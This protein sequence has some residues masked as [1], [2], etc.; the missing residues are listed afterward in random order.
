MSPVFVLN[1]WLPLTCVALWPTQRILS[2]TVVTCCL[3]TR[4]GLR[5]PDTTQSRTCCS[6]SCRCFHRVPSG[7]RDTQSATSSSQGGTQAEPISIRHVRGGEITARLN[8]WGS[9]QSTPLGCGRAPETCYRSSSRVGSYK[10]TLPRVG[11]EEHLTK[12]GRV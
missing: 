3:E 7:A 10:T 1:S 8:E 4:R 11:A 6:L 5:I 2:A 12:C 9:G